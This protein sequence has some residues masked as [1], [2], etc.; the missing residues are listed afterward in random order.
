MQAQNPMSETPRC[1]AHNRQGA[2]CGNPPIQGGTVCR[3]HGGA[4]PQVKASAQA[5]LAALID[6]AIDRLSRLLR[7]N[8]QQ[9]AMRAVKDVLDRNGLKSPEQLEV[10]G[11]D[12]GPIEVNANREQFLSRIADL[13]ARRSS[14]GGTSQAE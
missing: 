1:T 10:T 6:P 13:A 2:Q 14:D 3:M 5:R 9:V 8:D 11:A 7:T 12:G 4:A